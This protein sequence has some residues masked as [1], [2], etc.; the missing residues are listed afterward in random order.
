MMSIPSEKCFWVGV[1]RYEEEAMMLEKPVVREAN[2][3]QA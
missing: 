2:A 1:G 3:G